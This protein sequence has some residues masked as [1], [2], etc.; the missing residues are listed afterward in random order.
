MTAAAVSEGTEES[1]AT[2]P[3]EAVGNGILSLGEL[4]K[5]DFVEI[6]LNSFCFTENV[7]KSVTT[8]SFTHITGPE[9]ITGT[10]YALA[11][12]TIKNVSKAELPVYDFCIGEL[13]VNGYTYNVG[14]SDFDILEDNGSTASK[15]GPLIN[16]DL[17]FYL[18]V[19]AEL[20]NAP[21]SAVLKL[22]F[23]D[24]FDNMEL[25]RIRGDKDALEKCPYSYTYN[26]MSASAASGDAGAGNDQG[27]AVDSAATSDTA[28]AA[29]TAAASASAPE[30]AGSASA[31]VPLLAV[32][33]TVTSDDFEFTLNKIDFT[34]EL[35]PE[36][37]SSVYTSYTPASGKTYIHIDGTFYNKAKRDYCIRDLPVPS[38]DYDNGYTYDG[39]A[40]VLDPS[41][42]SSFV[43]ASHRV[44]CTPLETAHYHGLIECPKV[45]D[46]SDAPL[47]VTLTMPDGKIYKCI[48]RE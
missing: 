2:A 18:N 42:K 33:E 40:L 21:E 37:T 7:Q 35:L 31:D 8:G 14:A 44:A 34:Y 25:S 3:S 47:F 46:E 17:R 24:D 5:T 6:T 29:D 11:E 28:A 1:A 48:V 45:V 16:Y 27:S 43:W 19:P 38:A 36:D 10:Y 4:I 30:G 41:R 32:G 12:G 22:G 15:I 13:N 26:L 20:A 23:F 39:F 9:P